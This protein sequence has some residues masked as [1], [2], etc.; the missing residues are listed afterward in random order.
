[1]LCRTSDASLI[2]LSGSLDFPCDQEKQMVL[3]VHSNLKRYVRRKIWD[4]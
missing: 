1:M 4:S 3:L 2:D